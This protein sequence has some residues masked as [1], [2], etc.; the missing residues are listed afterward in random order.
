MMRMG[1][2]S[3]ITWYRPNFRLARESGHPG[4]LA[5]R[6]PW[7]PAFAGTTDREQV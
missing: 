3:R 5:Q 2:V 6:R 7:V 1:G 4:M